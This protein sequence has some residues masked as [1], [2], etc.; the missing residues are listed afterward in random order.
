MMRDRLR[1]GVSTVV[2]VLVF[3][4]ALTPCLGANEPSELVFEVQ[5]KLNG[6]GYRPGPLDGIMGQK[7]VAAIES[8]QRSRGL[9]VTGRL[10]LGTVE[11]LGLKDLVDTQVQEDIRQLSSGRHET[12]EQAK[13]QLIAIGRPAVQPLIEAL[14]HRNPRVRIEAADAL[15]YLGDPRAVD[16]LI[17]ALGDDVGMVRSWAEASLFQL[18]GKVFG[19]DPGRWRHWWGAHKDRY[20]NAP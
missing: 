20:L 1:S 6:L 10:G 12:V 14:Q 17:E 16:P 11:A 13:R 2:L 9:P 4:A 5:K 3:W 18:T 7:T 15:G 19:R 8:F